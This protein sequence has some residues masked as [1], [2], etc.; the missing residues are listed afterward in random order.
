VLARLLDLNRQR[1]EEERLAGATADAAAKPKK[2][3]KKRGAASGE[4]SA[5][6]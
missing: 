2:G 6:F 3:R 4:S 1:A 5:L